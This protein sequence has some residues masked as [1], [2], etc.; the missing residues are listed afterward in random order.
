MFG[1]NY[2]ER[3]GRGTRD[4]CLIALSRLHEK[5]ACDQILKS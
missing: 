5:S 4:E 2:T 3:V 1:P